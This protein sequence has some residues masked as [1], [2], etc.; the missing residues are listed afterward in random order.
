MA[1]KRMFSL[2]VV[3][4]DPFLDMPHS[5]QLLYFHLAMRADDDGFVA[6]PKK[7]MRMLGNQDD[8]FKI[9]IAKRFII[10]FQSG[11]CVIKHWLIHN[12]I[13]KDRYTETQWIDE[14]KQILVDNKT[15]K[16]SL[17]N[18]NEKR[19]SSGNQTA[20]KRQR[21][22]GKVRLGKVSNNINE[23]FNNFWNLYNKK[24]D[25]PKCEHKWNKLLDKDREDIIK[26]LDDYVKATPD[27]Q[28]RKNPSTYLNNKSWENEIIE[29]KG[30]VR[31][32]HDNSKAVLKNGV[33]I[34]PEN[35]TAYNL[36]YYP[37]LAKDI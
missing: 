32:L 35:K 15:K 10:P 21:R 31:I 2:D 16:Y 22:L 1:K 6:N 12:L 8:D 7:I 4:T 36:S 11:I 23:S 13:R 24:I 18:K 29:N 34:D 17:N 27:K 14:K 5:S 9:L 20:T 30:N 33:W 19:L 26:H 3:D 28:Y 37:E 25:K